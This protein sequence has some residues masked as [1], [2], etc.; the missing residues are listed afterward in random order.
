[1]AHTTRWKLSDIFLGVRWRS[2]GVA[3]IFD[4]LSGSD[5]SSLCF[6][7]AS[8]H[9]VLTRMLVKSLYTPSVL[10]AGVAWKWRSAEDGG[11]AL[12]KARKHRMDG[13]VPYQ[14]IR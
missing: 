13:I 12:R 7:K 5:P 4:V 3:G 2:E 6:L 8:T 11:E 10:Q 14:K 9:G 1:M